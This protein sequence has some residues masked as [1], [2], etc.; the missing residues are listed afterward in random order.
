VRSL[1]RENAVVVCAAAVALLLMAWLGLY[2]WAWTDWDNE[3]R[4]AVDALI[5]GH[6]G[7]FLHLAPAYGGSL[8]LRAPFFMVTALWHG[9]QLAIYRAS[10]APCLLATGALGIWLCARLRAAGRPL[11]TRALVLALCVANPLTLSALQEGHPEELLGAALCVAAVLCAIHERPVWAAVALG[12]A[13]ANK[14]WAA[15]AVGPVLVALPHARLRTVLIA[16]AVAGAV[17][18][19]LILGASGGLVGQASAGGLSTGTIFQPWQLWWFLGS[20]GHVV[21]GLYGNAKVGYRVPPAWLGGYGHI[22]IVAIMPPLSLLYARRQGKA[23]RRAGNGA[24]LLLALLLALRC[25]LDPWDTGYYALPFLT[26]L[27]TWESLSFDRPPALA[28]LGAFAAWFVF[29]RTSSLALSADVQALV[30]TLVSVAAV[31]ALAVALYAPG[32]GERL[33]G[34]SARRVHRHAEEWRR[35][36]TPEPGIGT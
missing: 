32:V 5:A 8:I 30:F 25:V 29:E 19:P 6:V 16:G 23:G 2:G 15:L 13:I 17:M 27:V 28:L 18:A 14:E 26:A 11:G 3:A 7:R 12:L 24:L 20:H 31:G 1:V 34:R 21:T 9:G 35:T 36:P 10:A 4:P 22:L 33:R